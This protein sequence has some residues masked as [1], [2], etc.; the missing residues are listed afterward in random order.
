MIEKPKQICDDCHAQLADSFVSQFW[1]YC[2]HSRTMARRLPKHEGWT[3]HRGV[4][5][6]KAQAHIAAALAGAEQHF[7]KQGKTLETAFGMC[8]ALFEHERRMPPSPHR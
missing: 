2:S 7:A 4:S 3:L 1:L 8:Q 5:P 6:A